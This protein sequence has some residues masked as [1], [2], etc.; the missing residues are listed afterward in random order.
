MLLGGPPQIPGETPK[1]APPELLLQGCTSFLIFRSTLYA[2][3]HRL[4]TDTAATMSQ[5]KRPDPV[6]SFALNTPL[7][8]KLA[9][10]RVILASSSP[11]RKD[12]LAS[13]V[14]NPTW[15]HRSGDR[16]FAIA[17]QNKKEQE[18]CADKNLHALAFDTGMI[19]PGAGDRSKHFR[20]GSSQERVYRRSG[21]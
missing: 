5:T 1:K 15:L 13:V 7:F 20:R 18:T 17:R 14:S 9:G 10:K 11:R 8:N 2:H 21:L 6:T 16:Q 19:G 4:G 3:H 12:I